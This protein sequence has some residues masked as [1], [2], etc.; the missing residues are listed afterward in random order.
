M[1]IQIAK[2]AGFC[3]GV[4]R[5][6]EMVMDAPAKNVKPIHT[7]GPLIHN[8]QVLMLLKEKGIAILE[9][10][11]G[12]GTGTVLIRAHGV[13]P[14]TRKCLKQAGFNVLDA[15]CPRVVKVQSII[16]KHTKRGFSSIIIGDREHPEVIGL[17]GFSG[18]K[19]YVAGSIEDLEKLPVFDQAIMV[20]QTTQNIRLYSEIKK[21]V[22][23]TH[24]NYRIFDTICHSTEKRQVEVS[25]LARDVDA[26]L[27]VGG[28]NSGN[29]QRLAEISRQTGKP[30]LHIETEEDLEVSDIKE[31]SQYQNIG[32]TAGASTPNWIIKRVYRAL[33]IIFL[34]KMRGWRKGMF[35]IQ[36]TLL[37]TNIYVSIG[38]GCLCY[39][40]TK[41]QGINNF[42]PYVVISI[43]YVQSMHILNHLTGS[44][45]DRY[46]DPER[47]HF[48]KKYK[49]LLSGLAVI[50]GGIGLL[51]AYTAGLIP[52]IVLLAMSMLGLSYNLKLV[53]KRVIATR[54]SRI[55]DIPGSKTILIAM[56]WGIVTAIIPPLSD[57]SK[58]NISTA[59]IFFWST[60]MVFVRSAFFD[61]LDIQGDR[62]VGKETIPI[63]IG[64]KKTTRLLRSIIFFILIVLFISSA[65][66]L[67]SSLGYLLA[68]CPVIMLIVLR[69]YETGRLLPGIRL[70]FLVETVFILTGIITYL[71]AII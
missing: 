34:K 38:A 18:N 25:Q 64:E 46:N 59:A 7:F 60:G 5:A 21:W 14:E 36:R 20:A 10:I 47:A 22:Q 70:E 17:L 32:I 61:T 16:K 62:I 24:P 56:A 4:R 23:R 52:F 15:T 3:M 51:T 31:L 53:P 30:T 66:G 35:I 39:A 29:T 37:L 42:L 19:G 69:N 55:K 2:T 6:V 12:Q 50:A 9:E 40:C 63:L 54:Y 71:W 27:V 67:T 48:Y 68:I 8:S 1:K 13:P 49:I 44:Q 43:L 57:Y 41:L 58:I 28:L 33:E 45:A 26:I 11:P 65:S